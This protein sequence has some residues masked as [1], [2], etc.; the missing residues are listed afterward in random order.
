MPI[1]NAVKVLVFLTAFVCA[2]CAHAPA[3][4]PAAPEPPDPQLIFVQARYAQNQGDWDEALRLYESLDTPYSRLARAR[5]HFVNGDNDAALTLVDGLLSEDTYADDALELR[6]KIR[7]RTGNWQGAVED[8]EILAAHHPDNRELLLFLARL[9]MVVSD[10][11]EA[12]EIIEQLLVEGE[13]PPLYY[14]L[15][16][17]CL[18]QRD[19]VSARKSL[20]RLLDLDPDYQ[21]AYLDL[22][23]IYELRRQ[24]ARAE[25]TYR[26]LLERDPQNQ[27]ALSALINL[28]I[29]Q[30]RYA[31]TLEPL[32]TLVMLSPEQEGRD[33]LIALLLKLQRHQDVAD[34]LEPISEKSALENYYLALAYAGLG[35][36]E[37]ALAQLDALPPEGGDLSCSFTLL[38]GSILSETGRKAETL[39]L[40]EEAWTRTPRPCNDIGYELAM[41][42]ETAGR[43]DEGLAVARSILN[44]H[45]DDPIALNFVG[46]VWAD[47]GLHLEEA[48]AMVSRALDQR[49]DDAFIID[50]LAWVLHRLGRNQ[51]AYETMQEAL[52]LNDDDPTMNEHMGDIL[53]NLDRPL[54]ALDHYLKARVLERAP[55]PELDKKIRDLK[56]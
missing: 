54:K 48:Y 55:S 46:Y 52:E 4:V 42:L 2:G 36:H 10:F 25:A 6:T 19:F 29:T 5:I 24:P 33:K 30:D 27:E 45:P 50:S 3:P 26:A 53:V 22:G 32:Q 21:P 9:K 40:L 28:L 47:E 20:Q 15:S 8:A 11:G 38:K 34:L 51:E 39:A 44:T 12:R 17:A 49:P 35:R 37:A 56:L 23:H 13:Q 41:S 7:T 43:R 14:E 1:P 18:G 16:K 31:D